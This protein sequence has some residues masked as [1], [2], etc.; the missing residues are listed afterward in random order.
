MRTWEFKEHSTGRLIRID[1]VHSYNAWDQLNKI[2]GIKQINSQ[3]WSYSYVC[4]TC[5][6]TSGATLFCS[7]E[8]ANPG[9]A[10]TS[11]PP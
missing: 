7:I 9:T 4:P 5:H 3:D 8:C 11:S 10:V 2:I 1:A 6:K